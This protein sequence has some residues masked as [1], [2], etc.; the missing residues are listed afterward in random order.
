M[1]PFKIMILKILLLYLPSIQKRVTIYIREGGV[2]FMK[3]ENG[4]VYI[5]REPRE[6]QKNPSLFNYYITDDMG[7]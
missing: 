7:E 1:P 3:F 4:Q 6:I 5:L 2:N